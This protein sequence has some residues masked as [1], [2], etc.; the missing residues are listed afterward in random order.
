MGSLLSQ[1]EPPAIDIV[2]MI[3]LSPELTD[4]QLLEFLV[5]D[6]TPLITQD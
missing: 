3:E 5:L 4:E 2:M 1:Q 6:L